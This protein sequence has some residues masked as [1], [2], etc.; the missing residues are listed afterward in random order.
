MFMAGMA[1]KGTDS[2]A[3]MVVMAAGVA[4]GGW[5]VV[6]NLENRHEGEAGDVP[7][8]LRLVVLRQ[9]VPAHLI[10]DTHCCIRPQHSLSRLGSVSQGLPG[11]LR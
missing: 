5:V 9:A 11:L 10:S 7:V 4:Y 3:P 8:Q 6:E 2:N 1:R